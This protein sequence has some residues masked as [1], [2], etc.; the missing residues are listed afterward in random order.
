RSVVE[1]LRLTVSDLFIAG[2]ETTA[3]SLNWAVL[4]LT[5]FPEIQKKVQTEILQVVGES[6][7]PTVA[8]RS[9]MPFT[10]AFVNETLRKSSHTTYG[11]MHRALQDTEL[12]GY[13]IPKGSW[14]NCFQYYIHHDPRIWGDPENFRPERFLTT[15]SDGIQ[16]VKKFDEFLPFSIGKRLCIGEQLAKDEL[17]VFLTCLYQVF[18]THFDPND[19]HPSIHTRTSMFRNPEYFKV[20]LT[21]RR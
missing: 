15:D 19:T 12:N 18:D 6:R 10:E 9:N 7:T 5:K 11:V 13:L 20:V 21:E 1:S 17:F 8:D 16:T 3:S 4:F 2:S 14:V